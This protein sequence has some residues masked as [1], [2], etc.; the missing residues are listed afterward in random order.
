MRGRKPGQKD[1]LSFPPAEGAAGQTVRLLAS[2]CL[3]GE[4]LKSLLS[5]IEQAE[6]SGDGKSSAPASLVPNHAGSA[7]R[8]WEEQL[9]KWKQRRGRGV[10][11]EAVGEGW[12]AREGRGRL[13]AT[14]SPTQVTHTPP[15]ARK[16]EIFII[17]RRGGWKC[18]E[19]TQEEGRACTR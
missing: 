14:F 12:G 7:P 17:I 9:P 8:S 4:G 15:L 13:R 10:P 11:G 19:S 3:R 16:V 6:L 5:G 2:G 18:L 1:Q